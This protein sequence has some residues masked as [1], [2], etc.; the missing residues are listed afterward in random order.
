MPAPDAQTGYAYDAIGRVYAR[1][2]RPD[3]RIQRAIDRALGDAPSV[4]S[5]G[6]GTGSYEPRDRCVVAVEPARV[7]I[8]QRRPGAGRAV[9]GVAEALPF[10][11]HRFDAALATLTVHH[12]RDPRAGLREMRRVSRRQVVLGF[13]PGWHGALWL[14]RD[15]VPAVAELDLGRAPCLADQVRW[16]ECTRV[17]PVLIP[18]DCVDG[19]LGAYWRRPHAYLDPEVRACISSLAVLPPRQLEPGLERLERDLSTGRWH[20]TYRHLLEREALDLGYRLLIAG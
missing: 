20:E 5:V 8:R 12:W 13:D 2:R 15:Y 11:S 4:V 9:R 6:A 7:M 3:P 16:L 18:H 1:R 19:F 14:T 17:E 10:A